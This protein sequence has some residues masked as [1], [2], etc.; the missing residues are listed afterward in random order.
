MLADDGVGK[1]AP[2]RVGEYPVGNTCCVTKSVGKHK[3]L[4]Q[5][6]KLIH[7][8]VA[9]GVNDKKKRGYGLSLLS[10]LSFSA[11]YHKSQ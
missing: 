4:A 11:T 8:A 7:L 3:E 5:A 6:P 9:P 10:F 2:Y 1:G